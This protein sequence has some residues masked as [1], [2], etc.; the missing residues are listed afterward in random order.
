MS[1]N[2]KS[3]IKVYLLYA[4]IFIFA[5][6]AVACF[7]LYLTYAREKDRI[8]ADLAADTAV[9][10]QTLTEYLDY[11]ALVTK[12]AGEQVASTIDGG[13][14]LQDIAHVLATYHMDAGDGE[15][16]TNTV[17]DW[18]DKDGRVVVASTKGVLEKPIDISR[19]EY[20][21]QAKSDPGNFK[22][23]E[24]DMGI[25]SL[26]RI[27]PV[28][29]GVTGKNNELLGFMTTGL[30]IDRFTEKA[31][32]KAQ[33]DKLSLLILTPKRGIVAEHPRGRFSA[34]QE[35]MEK[36]ISEIDP[37]RK[38][39][40]LITPSLFFRH[41][42][43]MALYRTSP[44]YPYTII[45]ALDNVTFKKEFINVLLPR[46]VEIMLF[47]AVMIL[48]I[49]GIRRKIV[50]PIV[51]L[52]QAAENLSRGDSAQQVED[53]GFAET[54][55]LSRHLGKLGEYLSERKTSEGELKRKTMQLKE[56]KE[57]AEAANKGKSE[58]LAFVSH[59]IRT[60]LNAIMAFSEIMKNEAFGPL[61]NRKYAEYLG[62]I[63]KSSRYILGIL[64]DLMDINRAEAGTIELRK[65]RVNLGEIILESI[66]IINEDAKERGIEIVS[67]IKTDDLK[68][69]AD[70][71]GM[72]K[73][74][75][76]MV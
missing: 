26:K 72:R 74:M 13:G 4:K 30:D 41:G 31:L 51:S 64:N 16:L 23:S 49:G 15:T 28:A 63:G 8:Q 9:I 32:S 17:F 35:D 46:F 22:L 42:S 56:A 71:L 57:S 12:N 60:P 18:V 39:G 19:R 6:V 3:I 52:S 48:F 70:R 69:E 29:V 27:I 59:E 54:R 33:V 34:S 5:L 58:F 38:S 44:K 11:I 1:N 55:N 67:E 53:S 24:P 2:D 61:G 14:S 65:E 10:D 47:G 75:L 40:V 66:K 45:T 20:Y 21:E 25:I 73:I 62:D 68:V 50:N 43:S 36:L 76:K 37:A 7:F